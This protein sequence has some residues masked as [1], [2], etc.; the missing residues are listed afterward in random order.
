[1]SCLKSV[2]IQLYLDGELP[3]SQLLVTEAHLEQCASCRMAVEMHKQTLSALADDLEVLLPSDAKEIPP[4]IPPEQKTFSRFSP[5]WWSA[6]VI[7][8]VT[9]GVVFNWNNNEADQQFLMEH[10]ALEMMYEED[11][12]AQWHNR[13]I[14]IV[15]IEDVDNL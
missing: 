2:D 1:M 12:N 9:F 15:I 13:E 8:I 4:F 10:M 7:I 5:W 3:A 11:L 6:A 14:S